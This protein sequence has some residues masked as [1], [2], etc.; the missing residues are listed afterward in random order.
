MSLNPSLFFKEF[1]GVHTCTENDTLRTILDAIAVM[2]IHRLI[3]IDEKGHLKGMISLSDI[4][5]HLIKQ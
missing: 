1:D 3:I 4:L 2:T 5:K